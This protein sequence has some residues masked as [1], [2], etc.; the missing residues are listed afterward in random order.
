MKH[1]PTPWYTNEDRPHVIDSD[2]LKGIAGALGAFYE[3]DQE[4]GN[5]QDVANAARIVACVNAFDGIENP[6]H[7]IDEM[8][9]LHKDYIRETIE[10]RD[11]NKSLREK[12]DI[13]LAE[14]ARVNKDAHDKLMEHP[15]YASFANKTGVHRY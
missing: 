7:Y 8:R 15:S 14:V 5:E 4:V 3:A 10:L 9:K 13:A 2:T 12:L 1:T 11:E 6:Q